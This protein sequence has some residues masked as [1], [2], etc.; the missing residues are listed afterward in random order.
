M[1]KI[2]LTLIIT[3]LLISCFFNKYEKRIKGNY[4][5]EKAEYLSLNDSSIIEG[6]L[7]D[8]YLKKYVSHGSVHIKGTKIGAFVD[9]SGYFNLKIPPGKYVFIAT[10]IGCTDM[11]TNEI[12]LKKNEK[13]SITFH[14]GTHAMYEK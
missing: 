6:F 2:L 9:T 7:Y 12:T 8:I 4:T 13:K 3:L 11:P 5:F 1:K 14:L 10:S